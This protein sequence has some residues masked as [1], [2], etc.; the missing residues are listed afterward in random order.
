MIRPRDSDEVVNEWRSQ[1]ELKK[2]RYE[3]KWFVSTYLRN[4]RD[5][6][7]MFK[8]NFLVVFFTLMGETIKNNNVNQR[9]LTSV[10]DSS[11]IPNFN[12]CNY[13]VRLLKRTRSSWNETLE[14]NGSITLLKVCVN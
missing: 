8:L 5:I 4:K 3:P 1:F 13:I 14:Y 10:S 9:F 7:R 11:M 6:G 12:W 2:Q